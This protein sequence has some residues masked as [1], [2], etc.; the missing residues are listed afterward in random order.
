MKKTVTF[1]TAMLCVLAVYAQ[2]KQPLKV[3][4]VGGSADWEKENPA[5]QQEQIAKRTASFENYLK[6][7]FTQVQVVNGKEYDAQMSAGYDVTIFDGALQRKS[8]SVVTKDEKG[9]VKNYY[10]AKSVVGEDF[11]FPAIFIAETGEGIGRSI[12]TKTDW[13]C[14]C[15]DAYA[16]HTNFNHQIFK[17]P[18]AVKIVQQEKPTPTDAYHYK[19]YYT[20]KFPDK[21]QMWQVQ[22]KGYMTNPGFR[23]G[24]VSRPWGFT[25]SPE[26]E[27]I[28][29]GVCAK[30]L[31]AVALGR[32]GNFF[33]WGFSASPDYMT[34]QAKQVF[35]NAVVY[36]STLKGEKIIARK[37]Y[38]RAATREYVKELTYFASK[39]AYDESVKESEQWYNETVE[40]KAALVAKKAKGETLS[41]NEE[42]FVNM[43]V[44][45]DEITY[46]DYLKKQMRNGY[47][48]MFNGDVK[49]FNKYLKDNTPYLYGA[50]MFYQYIVDEDAKSL[51]I[52]NNDIALLDKA[53]S[54]LESG[55]EM[56]KAQRILDRYTLCTFTK[57]TQW[58]QWF[59]EN[60]SRIFFTEAGGWLFL[61][62]TTNPAVE[63]NDYQKKANYL[64]AK[65]IELAQTNDITPVS[66][67]ATLVTYHNGLQAVLVKFK[68]DSRY[69]IYAN[70]S[71]KDPYIKTSVNI[72]LP[73]GYTAGSLKIP[74]GKYFSG[75]GTTKYEDEAIFIQPIS[76]FG[77][78]TIKI[79]CA[80]QCCD[81]QICFPPAEKKIEIRTTLEK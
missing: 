33:F 42:Q 25:D 41:K 30:T 8:P 66:V 44:E 64:A 53:I 59:N 28:S 4:Y 36:T 29:S 24:M 19:Y 16:H 75:N 58:R 63:G 72:Q 22:T 49:A 55:K 40:K 71:E 77:K 11:N 15:L 80:W 78:G 65:K 6:S 56:E 23:V 57:P 31:D 13:Y 52:A 7:Y 9:N 14:L 35:A 70:V 37:Y 73:D 76:G 51:K 10:G 5:Q 45:K 2:Q 17:G 32:H 34:D 48:E 46:D 69:H 38:D 74:S 1:I 3:L 20:G 54:L 43:P 67:G 18:F 39:E 50:A 81:S 79:N 21:I 12:G 68:I 47:Y 61:V 26:A 62:N 60:K 27:S